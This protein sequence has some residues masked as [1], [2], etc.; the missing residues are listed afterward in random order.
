MTGTEVTMTRHIGRARTVFISASADATTARVGARCVLKAL[1]LLS[2]P[3]RTAA[4]GTVRPT[5]AAY[6]TSDDDTAAHAPFNRDASSDRA[7]SIEA[8]QPSIEKPEDLCPV[9]E[10]DWAGVQQ[11]NKP[12]LA[13][14]ESSHSVMTWRNE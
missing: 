6:I 4:V 8:N 3:R 10:D 11:F 12:R 13:D 5:T 2:A 9:S 7:L 1:L 14:P